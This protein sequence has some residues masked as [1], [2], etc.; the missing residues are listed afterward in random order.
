MTATVEKRGNEWYY[1][2]KGEARM[3]PP[4]RINWFDRD[5]QWK[6]MKGFR[7]KHDLEKPLG[8]WMTIL[9]GATV[10]DGTGARGTV[11]D[12]VV[13]NGVVEHV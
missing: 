12:V 8:E 13:H 10:V 6:D 11:T 9:R 2:P 5:P 4:G 1:N 7:G 3:F